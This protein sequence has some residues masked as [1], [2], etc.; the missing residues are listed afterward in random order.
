MPDK[1]KYTKFER[2]RIIGAR[3]LQ[4]S[5]NAPILLKF[6]KEELEKMNYDPIKISELEF[7][8]GILPITVNRPMPKKTDRKEP[9]MPELVKEV[10]EEKE[11]KKVKEVVV[12]PVVGEEK[13]AGEKTADT[14]EAED[15]MTEEYEKLE[16]EAEVEE[17]PAEAV[18]GEGE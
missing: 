10:D 4:I 13:K 6:E 12:A 1:E 3:A 5:A 17:E 15:E 14:S 9:D 8:A 16:G 18:G 11:K 2:A 7:N